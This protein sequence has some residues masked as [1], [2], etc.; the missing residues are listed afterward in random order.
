MSIPSDLPFHIGKYQVQAELGRGATGVVYLAVDGFK[1]R[2]VAIK[3]VHAHLLRK[4]RG[5]VP[6][7][8]GET[9]LEHART[10]L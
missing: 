5:V 7:P 2:Q 8:A 6:T 9:L 1:G 10:M 4:P 3:E